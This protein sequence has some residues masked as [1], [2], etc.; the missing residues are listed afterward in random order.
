MSS[1][2]DPSSGRSAHL[3]VTR[4]ASGSKPR[5][6][7]LGSSFAGLTTARFIRDRTGE[8]VELTVI[9]RNP[10]LTF[11]PNIQ[12]EVFAD[13]DPLAT[14][15]LD[16]P[17]IHAKDG[18][19]FLNADVVDL[20]PDAKS[21][22]VVASDRP[23][24]AAETVCYDY[25]VVALGSRLA[26]D[27]IEG[28]GEYGD[29]VSSAYYGNKL[30]RRLAEYRGG[31]IAIGS[32]RFHQGM[33]KKPEW[34]P[35]ALAACEGPPLE[36]GLSMAHWLTEHHR[37]D[38]H[39]VTLFTPAEMIAEDAGEP[40]VTPFLEMATSMGFGYLNKTEDVVRLDADGIEF[41]SG[42]TLEAEIK[43]V[44]PDW[45]PHPFLKDLPITDELGFVETDRWMRNSSYPEVFAV[46]DAAAI[47]VPK[48]GSLGHQ[49][50]EIVARQIGV[51]V[52][53]LAP[54][55]AGEQY[56][57]EILCFGDTGGHKGFYIYSD[58]WFGGHKS[59]FKMGY[60]P[61]AMKL[62]FKEMYFRT[63]GKPPTFG[64]PA[65]HLLMDHFPGE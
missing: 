18:N 27:H 13:R 19:I 55:D 1:P 7:V 59:V 61:Y 17:P 42:A 51:E 12:M 39:L 30:R 26:Y 9:D 37:G 49:Q 34:L 41:Q 44:I 60:A 25:L 22:E 48:L 2:S 14:M 28:F 20:D 10:Y 64:V 33:D 65:T 4:V 53:S 11:V 38:A 54:G 58:V 56:H 57:P 31:P 50:A 3:G 35:V 63:G 52:G 40:I 47:T 45:V 62:A 21:V 36:L 29:T 23:G 15:L 6:V 16:T 8:D 32:A 43:I 46:G 24:S 5:V